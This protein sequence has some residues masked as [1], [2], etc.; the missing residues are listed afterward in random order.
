MRA[1][2]TDNMDRPLHKKFK[3]Y[4]VRP[5]YYLHFDPRGRVPH[6]LPGGQVGIHVLL[7][8]GLDNLHPFPSTKHRYHTINI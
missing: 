5:K 6:T 1:S 4:A 3:G 7:A 2:A 8:A